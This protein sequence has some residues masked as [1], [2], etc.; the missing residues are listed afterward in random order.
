[1]LKRQRSADVR[2]TV[3]LD[4]IPLGNG[5]ITFVPADPKK[6]KRLSQRITNGAYAFPARIQTGTYHVEI[7]VP[8]PTANGTVETIP[9]QYNSRTTL[10]VSFP[11][12]STTVDFAL[13]K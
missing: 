6:T 5:V 4:G 7:S 9:P 1:M 10:V 8:K 11:P 3:T 13:S 2:G 12:G